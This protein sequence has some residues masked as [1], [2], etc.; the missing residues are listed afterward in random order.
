MA[1]KSLNMICATLND[2]EILNIYIPMILKLANNDQN[3]T[4]RVSAVNLMYSIYPK[5][6]SQ[7]EKIRQFFYYYMIYLIFYKKSKFSELCNEDTPMVRRA[8]ATKIGDF[9]KSLEKEF[10][11]GEIIALFKQLTTDDQVKFL[12]I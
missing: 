9:A 5:S 6:G 10:V 11:L 7:K 4:C 2:Y 1:V 3:F 8:V 12:F